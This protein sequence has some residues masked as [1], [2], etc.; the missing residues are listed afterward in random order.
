MDSTTVDSFRPEHYERFAQ[1]E[2]ANQSFLE[3]LKAN[4]GEVHAVSK[5][6][7]F[8]HRV[9]TH[10]PAATVLLNDDKKTPWASLKAPE[11]FE[12]ERVVGLNPLS[13]MGSGDKLDADA[14]KIESAMKEDDSVRGEGGILV[15]VIDT[16][17]ELQAMNQIAYAQVLRFQK[18]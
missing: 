14:G 7:T 13:V 16:M 17:K 12:S 4:E 11:G 18:G 9:S 10:R 6:T 3:E 15:G 8:S 1:D 2:S 5:H